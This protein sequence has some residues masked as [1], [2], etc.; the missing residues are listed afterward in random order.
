MKKILHKIWIR[1]INKY[2]LFSALS[3]IFL[4]SANYII[5]NLPIFTGEN[6]DEQ[7]VMQII[8]EKIGRKE[9]IQYDSITFINVSNDKQL[10]YER[11]KDGN[12]IK[13]D[14]IT[15]RK[16]LIQLLSLLEKSASYK[17]LILD[18]MFCKG[19]TTEHDEELF[20]LISRMNNIV[21]VDHDSIE[22]AHPCLKEKSAIAEYSATITATNFTRYEYLRGDKR[23]LPLKIYEELNPKKKINRYGW[24]W[25]S[26][27]LTDGNLCQKS[28][29]LT[30]DTK[31]FDNK[32]FVDSLRQ[33]NGF[34]NMGSDILMKID[35]ENVNLNEDAMIKKLS[36][37]NKNKYVIIG[38]LIED[39]HDTYA[40]AKPGSLIL[41]RALQFLNQDRHLVKL[42]HLLFWLF[43]YFIV[44]LFILK[45][46]SVLLY[47]PLIRNCKFK[48]VHYFVNSLSYTLFFF[49]LECTEY[50]IFHSVYSQILPITYFYL[51]KLIIDFKQYK[52]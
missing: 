11:N 44:T 41:I 18:M 50:I 33:V 29:F 23:V 12:V 24:G 36:T 3:A 35:N 30:F 6:L 38:N 9:I 40:G 45:R 25:F 26:A 37:L 27:Y 46:N 20:E 42:S 2:I 28:V 15:D 7:F 14:A 32:V 34:Y 4:V 16:K 17:Y 19:D 47:L 51:I 1:V 49:A 22:I 5:N 13:T 10:I 8:S 48:I 21:F 52:I 31:S 43:I 39:V